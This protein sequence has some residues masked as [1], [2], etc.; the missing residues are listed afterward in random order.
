MNPWIFFDP[1]LLL[2]RSGDFN[3]L[4]SILFFTTAICICA[5]LIQKPKNGDD[6]A[7]GLSRAMFMMCLLMMTLQEIYMLFYLNNTIVVG[8]DW[9]FHRGF[10]IATCV[11][12]II[13]IATCIIA[14]SIRY[15]TRPSLSALDITG[16]TAAILS[17]ILHHQI[18]DIA[19]VII[20][21]A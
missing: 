6:F 11:I 3:L 5:I 18:R 17:V 9:P 13:V 15:G 20:K 16:I 21:S 4:V 2:L 8:V 12:C 7:F 14:T 10:I 19:C 1:K